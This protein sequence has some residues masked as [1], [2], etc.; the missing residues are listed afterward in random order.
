[1]SASAA[2]SEPAVA[3]IAKL[4]AAPRLLAR[5]DDRGHHEWRLGAPSYAA[6]RELPRLERNRAVAPA[7]GGGHVGSAAALG[8]SVL[9][10]SARTSGAADHRTRPRSCGGSAR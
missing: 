9:G 8:Q 6:G 7:G 5:A 4:F 1:M 2:C 10:P 3:S